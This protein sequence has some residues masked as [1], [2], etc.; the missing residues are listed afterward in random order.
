VSALARQL[1]VPPESK[2]P[3]AG[4][5]VRSLLAKLDK[6]D[7]QALERVLADPKVPTNFIVTIL[8]GRGPSH[9]P[10]R[11]RPLPGLAVSDLAAALSAPP[12]TSRVVEEKLCEQCRRP[13][14]PLNKVHKFCKQQCRWD[15][16]A[17]RTAEESRRRDETGFAWDPVRPAHIVKVTVP[18]QRKFH[19]VP[20]VKGWLTAAILPDQQFGYRRYL[21]TGE[22]DPFHDPRAIEIAEKIVEAERPNKTVMLGD[23]ND[24]PTYGR[25]TQEPEFVGGVQ[26]GCDRASVHVATVSEASDETILLEGNHDLRIQKHALDNAL[27]SAGLRRARRSPGEYPILTMPF[28]LGIDEMK[29]VRWVGGYPSGAHYVNE[30]LATIHG[31]VTGQ[32]LA[33]KTINR[34][35]VTTVFGH[36]HQFVDDVDT[37]NVHGRP[38]FVRAYSPGCLCRIDGAVPSVKSGR[39]PFARPAESWENWQQGMLIVRY[40]P[41]NDRFVFEDVRIY[42]GWAMHRGQ[43]FTSEKDVRDPEYHLLPD[44]QRRL[45]KSA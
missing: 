41:G 26:P 9:L 32:N 10:Q 15:H 8:R 44:E 20:L 17:M 37:F 7:R 33:Q 16:A 19:S 24:L 21:D 30:N 18:K 1:L 34:E 36:V 4:D 14:L 28:I 42:E 38:I 29:N 45:R 40:L 2:R 23:I 3:K 6:Q 39:D 12:A 25:Y 43:E 35:R 22:L 5:K 27:A 31:R 13:F 11:D